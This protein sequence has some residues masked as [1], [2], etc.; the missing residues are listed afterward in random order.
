MTARIQR[1]AQPLRVAAAFL[2][3][4][5]AACSS[6]TESMAPDV[7]AVVAFEGA[8]LAKLLV[9]GNSSGDLP[10]IGVR[11]PYL[12]FQDRACP[13]LSDTT[14][15][16]GNGIP[17]DMVV[18]YATGGCPG[19]LGVLSGRIRVADLNGPWN[20]RVTYERFEA[21]QT[22]LLRQ[23]WMIAD[24]VFHYRGTS[25]STFEAHN[26]TRVTSG[27]DHLYTSYAITRGYDLRVVYTGPIRI[28]DGRHLQGLRHSVV[29]S[30]SYY[31]VRGL[32]GPRDSTRFDV[33]TLVPLKEKS[34]TNADCPVSA[35]TLR[36]TASG[37]LNGTADFTF[38]CG[39]EF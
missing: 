32:R 16:N 1:S 12:I 15:T 8:E 21:R 30:G 14:D 7:G 17:D 35:G 33:T 23:D 20:V 25:D 36:L 38:D 10:H 4:L 34:A 6:T 28:F 11:L 26:Q 13:T 9:R 27:G 5:A 22:G 3:P 2:L 37:A 19:G 24:G 18:Q 31:T 29:V 39:S